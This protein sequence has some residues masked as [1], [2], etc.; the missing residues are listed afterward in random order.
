MKT[1][2]DL[3]KNPKPFFKIQRMKPKLNDPDPARVSEDLVDHDP[4]LRG[5]VR[6]DNQREYLVEVGPFQ[7]RLSC[8]PTNPDIPQGK[9]NRFSPRWY[10]ECP[11]LEYSIERDAGFCFV[12]SLFDDTPAKETADPSWKTTDIRKWHKMKSV[13][14]SKHGKLAQHFSSRSHKAPLGAHCHFPKKPSI[15]TS[16]WIKQKEQRKFRKLKI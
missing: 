7:P 1:V 10:D 12:C 2:G 13:G 16:N 14:K 8:F 5:E 4:A 6:N 11:H 9:Q 15:S 3:L